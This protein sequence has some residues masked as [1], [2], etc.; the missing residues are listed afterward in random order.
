MDDLNP[1]W[2]S[3]GDNEVEV[4]VIQIEVEQFFIRCI[5]AYGPQEK[6]RIERKQNFWSRISKEVEEAYENDCAIIF[7]MDG[8][9]WAGNDV[10]K[11]DPNKCNGNGKLFKKFL[12]EHPYLCV[13]NSLDIC[14][15]IITRR[16]KLKNKTE[17]AVLD[18]FVVCEKIKTFIEKMIIDDNKEY[19][20]SRYTKDGKTDSDH[21]TLIFHMKLNFIQKRKDRIEMFNFRNLEGQEK[22]SNLTETKNEL[23]KCFLNSNNL[24]KQSNEWFRNLFKYFQQSFVKIRSCQTKK[25]LDDV[26][27]LLNKRKELIQKMKKA[28][29]DKKEELQ[30]KINQTESEIS[31][32]SALDNRNKVI[33]NFSSLARNDGTTNQNG[34]WA[35]KRKLFPKSRES[36]PF[37][38][39]DYEGKLISS[40]GELKGLYLKTFTS[41]LRHRPIKSELTELK[42]VKDELCARRLELAGLT[43][44][45]PWVRDDL[46]KVLSSLKD[47][48]ARDPH[49]LINELFKPG[50]AGEDFQLSF[51]IMANKI[52]KEIFVPKFMEFANIV[53]IYK[54]KGSKMNLENDRG[55]FI[56]NVFRSIL[57]KMVYHDKYSIVDKNM[58]DSNVGARRGKNIRNHIFVLNGIINEVINQKKTGIDITI[59]DY[60]QCFDS[61][62]MEEVMNDLW[63][64]GITDDKLGLIYKMNERTNVAVKTPFGLSERQEVNNVVMQGETSCVHL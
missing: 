20:L 4:L 23:L 53:S 29:D 49:S 3:E 56:V 22:F 2:I 11:G 27:I 9:L 31:K 41:R 47:G 33:D 17:E 10:I 60:R 63:E 25:K 48:K 59:L 58:S 46:N 34:V 1:V 13:V 45:E 38:K 64:A 52:K 61:L 12:K 54:G 35:L 16:R 24:S 40:Q 57:M 51:L 21:N 44:S 18:F 62:W 19:P 15:G 14:E 55:I 32:M 26:D 8:N 42:S 6:D 5:G 30:M 36:L 39:L 43:K 50:V 37:A 7:Q 28:D